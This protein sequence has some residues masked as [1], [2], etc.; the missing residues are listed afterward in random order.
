MFQSFNYRIKTPTIGNYQGE[1]CVTFDYYIC[2]ETLDNLAVYSKLSGL[3][4]INYVLKTQIEV[5]LFL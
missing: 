1:A 4:T 2:G 5:H 3:S